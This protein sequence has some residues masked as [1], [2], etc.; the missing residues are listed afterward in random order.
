MDDFESLGGALV[1]FGPI[2]QIGEMISPDWRIVI[3]FGL[4]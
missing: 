3:F 1:A 2:T 4:L